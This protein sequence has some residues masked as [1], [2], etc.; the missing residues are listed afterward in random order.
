MNALTCF[1]V[2]STSSSR[3]DWWSI[4]HHSS[5]KKKIN[6]FHVCRWKVDYKKIHLEQIEWNTAIALSTQ[7]KKLHTY[8]VIKCID[9]LFC[10]DNALAVVPQSVNTTFHHSLNHFWIGLMSAMV[11]V[12][13]IN[14]MFAEW[15]NNHLINSNFSDCIS[16]S[17]SI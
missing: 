12:K 1:L 13:H 11:S 16:Y 4:L 9:E 15:I 8:I 7:N 14:P 6:E 5:P 2:S 17:S 10:V 3:K